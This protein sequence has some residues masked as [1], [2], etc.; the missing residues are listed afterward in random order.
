[1]KKNE[2]GE[3][4]INCQQN[5]EYHKYGVFKHILHTIETVGTSQQIPLGD[6]QLKL[7]KWTML[8]HD[9]GKPYVKKLMK[10]EQ[11]V[12]QVTMINQLNLQLEY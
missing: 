6:W 4:V 9:I 1:M 2:F 11:I 10:M 3:N 7:L 5:S 12:S 8:F